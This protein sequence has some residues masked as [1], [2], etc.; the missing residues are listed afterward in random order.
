MVRRLTAHQIVQSLQNIASDCSDGELCDS[1]NPLRNDARPSAVESD[2]EPIVTDSSDEDT[3]HDAVTDSVGNDDGVQDFT[4]KDG[5]SWQKLSTFQVQ[6]GRLQQQNV[7]NVMP[8]PTAFATNCVIEGSPSSFRIIFSE[9]MLRNI[10]KCTISEAQRV[11]GDVNWKMTLR[12]LDK[13][14]GLIIT[15]GVLGQRGLPCSSL[16][17]TSWECPIFSNT[18]SRNRFME[19]MRFVRFDI[20]TERRHQLVE[21]KFCFASWL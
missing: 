15:R 8:G 11:T 12:E 10:Q 20:K 14:I 17:N 21:D 19:I 9:A 7:V 18:L 4:G 6:R 16:W 13:F 5:S 1:E 3:D 2:E